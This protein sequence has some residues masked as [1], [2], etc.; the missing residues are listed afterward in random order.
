M[1][2]ASGKQQP[3]AAPSLQGLVDCGEGFSPAVPLGAAAFHKVT[4]DILGQ[5]VKETGFCGGRGE[6]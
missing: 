3:H 6:F 5:P 2:P 1:L 4:G